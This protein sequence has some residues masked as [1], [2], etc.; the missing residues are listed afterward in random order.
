[1]IF[2]LRPKRPVGF[3]TKKAQ[4]DHNCYLEQLEEY[5]TSSADSKALSTARHRWIKQRRSNIFQPRSSFSLRSSHGG[6]L[7]VAHSE[8]LCL[9]KKKIIINYDAIFEQESGF[10]I[11][12]GSWE[13]LAAPVLLSCFVRNVPSRSRWETRSGELKLSS[14]THRPHKHICH[15]FTSG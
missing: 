5:W 15:K 13:V 1:M 7:T 3:V 8:G 2:I 14:S 6:S 12:C 4:S 9:E 11:V 10:I